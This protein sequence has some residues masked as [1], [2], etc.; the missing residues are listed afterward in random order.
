MPLSSLWISDKGDT[1][2]PCFHLRLPN[3][4]PS[5]STHTERERVSALRVAI[6]TGTHMT[7]GRGNAN[8]TLNEILQIIAGCKS[9]LRSTSTSPP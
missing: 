2:S 6:S 8:R 1:L 7:S 9:I 3:S 4:V 5:T